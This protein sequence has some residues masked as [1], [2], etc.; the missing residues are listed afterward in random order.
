MSDNSVRCCKQTTYISISAFKKQVFSKS[1][2]AKFPR[3]WSCSPI[4]ARSSSSSLIPPKPVYPDRG[5]TLSQG[6]RKDPNTLSRAVTHQSALTK[7]TNASTLHFLP[8]ITSSTDRG[9]QAPSPAQWKLCFNDTNTFRSPRPARNLGAREKS[10]PL[11][12]PFR[13]AHGKRM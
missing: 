10:V 5:A 3:C 1:V 6:E 9:P 11:D 4:S 12:L 2:T 8:Q 13:A 7:K